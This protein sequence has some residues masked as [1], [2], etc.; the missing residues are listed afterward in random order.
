MPPSF[1][2]PTYTLNISR[3]LECILRA[4]L[5]TKTDQN[6][7]YG[8]LSADHYEYLMQRHGRIALDPLPSM[9]ANNPY[10]WS[11]WNVSRANIDAP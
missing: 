2:G 1:D 11:T 10:N 8:D 3:K 6:H 9:D 4:I 7:G 5:P